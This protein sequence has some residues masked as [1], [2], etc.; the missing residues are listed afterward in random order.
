MALIICTE[1]GKEFSDKAPTCPQCGCPTSEVL[2][3]LSKNEPVSEMPAE[4]PIL[5]KCPI[6]GKTNDILQ[7]DYCED[8]GQRLTPYRHQ[9]KEFQIY[10]PS[11]MVP[12][13]HPYTICPVCHAFNETGTF[14]CVNCGHD[15]SFSEYSVI[16][17]RS[18]S[19]PKVV[20]PAC[21][22]DNVK[23]SI[24]TVS[25]SETVRGEV[26]KKSITT[27]AVNKTGRAVANMA[28]LGLWGAVLPKRSNYS[29][30]QKVT[31]NIIKHKYCVCQ[32]CGHFWET[33]L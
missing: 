23:I 28:T 7:N 21:G 16:I 15:Y 12:P 17:P 13:D 31:K 5:Q 14:K 6:C 9:E 22:G 1:C 20:C 8:C 32:T 26:R 2:K 24:E 18:Y 19:H 10:N 4:E 25:E 30:K 27:R 3:E 29:E 33:R 11:E